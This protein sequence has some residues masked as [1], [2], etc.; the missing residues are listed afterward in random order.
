VKGVHGPV[1][2]FII[3]ICKHVSNTLCER[4]PWTSQIFS[5]ATHYQHVSNTLATHFQHIRS[6]VSMDQSNPSLYIYVYICIGFR[7]KGMNI[8]VY[9]YVDVYISVPSTGEIDL[10]WVTLTTDQ[11]RY[12]T[13]PESD[14]RHWWDILRSD[15]RHWWDI[16]RSDPRHWWD[17]LRSPSD[18]PD[19]KTTWQYVK[20]SL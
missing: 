2:S 6:M 16:L 3:C 13:W 4:C 20:N 8:Y 7:V 17:I 14:P 15:P 1:K 12:L 10:S 5:L 19:L 18:W 9:V 11:V